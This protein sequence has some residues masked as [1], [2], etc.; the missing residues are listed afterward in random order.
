L[1][2]PP[3]PS[4]ADRLYQRLEALLDRERRETQISEAEVAAVL[5]RAQRHSAALVRA[6]RLMGGGD[7]K[8]WNPGRVD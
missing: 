7:R 8:G 2:K 5:A 4:A 3:K 1:S 6:A